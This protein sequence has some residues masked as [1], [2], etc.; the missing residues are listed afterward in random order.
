MQFLGPM[1]T[2]FK[3]NYRLATI[4]AQGNCQIYFSFFAV[5]LCIS[6]A[7]TV[8]RYTYVCMS[9]CLSVTFVY[10]DETNK[11]I[12]SNFFRHRLGGASSC[13]RRPESSSSTSVNESLIR[14][15]THT[16]QTG[17]TPHNSSGIIVRPTFFGISSFAFRNASTSCE[18][19]I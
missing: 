1:K 16:R 4:S 10:S 5:M 18:G 6:A 13:R 9:V 7:Y 17:S 3:V 14:Q 11:H 2:G 12:S 19:I 15:S 8:V